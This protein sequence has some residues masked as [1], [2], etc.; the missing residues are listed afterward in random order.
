[1]EQF[2]ELENAKMWIEGWKFKSRKSGAVKDTL[3]FKQGLL[4]TVNALVAVCRELIFKQGF[5]FILTSR[6]N[7]DVVENWFS[8]IRGKGHNNDSRTTLEY[9]SASKSI[10]VNWLL[11]HPEKGSNCQLDCDSFVGLL[12]QAELFKTKCDVACS[13][14]HVTT[15]GCD[16][17]HSASVSVSSADD[18]LHSVDTC[19]LISDWSSVF[20]LNDVDK[21]VIFYIAGYLSRKLSMNTSC[22]HCMASYISSRKWHGKSSVNHTAFSEMKQFEWS[23]Y[24]LASPSPQLFDLCCAME[25]IVQV[26]LE[27]VI[28]GPRVM[29]S[30]KD[31]IASAVAIDSY[32]IDECCDDHRSW[33]LNVAVTVFLRIRI[34]HFVRIRNREL[35]ELTNAAKIKKQTNARVEKSV[36]KPSRKAKK[37]MHL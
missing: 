27:G 37:V 7:Q 30:L 4:L 33:W 21:N 23:R 13:S 10:A 6:F 18:L 16:V 32:P 17:S 36:R 15:E 35:K 22:N 2:Q 8:C 12:K 1:V 26:N 31:I 34:H 11:E 29:G 28:A 5:Q 20:S 9:E 19:N 3:P 25:R 14:D 24:G